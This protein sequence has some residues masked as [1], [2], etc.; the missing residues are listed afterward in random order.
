VSAS[1]GV[2][3]SIKGSWA[4]QYGATF[5]DLSGNGNTATPVF[6]T[7]SSD[8]DVS[9]S[10][11]SYSPINLSVA[12]AGTIS[13]WPSMITAAPDQPA[14]MYT[15][16]TTPGIFFASFI[17]S[18]W[19]STIP[20]SF[21]WYNFAFLI[22]LLAGMGV[23]M[24]VASKGQNGLLLKMIVTAVLMIFFAL[25]GPNV[26]GMYVVIYYIMFCFGVI[27]LSRNYGW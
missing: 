6:R 7:T 3:A 16:N 17:H 25:P 21:F 26:Y 15:E 12:D 18:I 13:T 8:S 14:T 27:V 19:P 23:F 5:T 24:L 20:E 10:L 9:A 2:G 22:I 11:I 1:I 4:W